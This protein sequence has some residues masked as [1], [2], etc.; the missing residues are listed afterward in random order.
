MNRSK[1]A[2][3]IPAQIAGDL[4]ANIVS[5][6]L[7]AGTMLDGEVEASGQRQ[8]SRSAYRE[9]VRI[10]RAKGLVESRTKIG[11]MVSEI[12]KWHLLDPDV[13]RWMC[14]RDPSP[15][16]LISLFELRIMVEPEAAAFAAQR[17][18]QA[19]LYAMEDALTEMERE[20]LQTE[21]G[22]A[23]DRLFHSILL[24]ASQNAFL[25]TLS[26]SV[27]AAVDLSTFFK[28]RTRRLTRDAVPDHWRVQRAIAAGDPKAARKAM[29]QLVRSA[30]EDTT[31][32]AVNGTS[33]NLSAP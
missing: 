23:A 26:S 25:A 24:A 21:K 15:Q 29:R 33:V 12:E 19:Q 4:G 22:R 1:Q 7:K 2:Q 13:L 3:R 11:T 5:G 14:S 17:R 6:R 10:L 27:S 8:V 32:A 20:T 31:A 18:S 30:F 9:A 28:Q 16:L